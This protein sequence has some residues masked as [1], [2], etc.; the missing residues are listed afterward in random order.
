MKNYYSFLRQKL[1]KIK[2]NFFFR[3]KILIEI[4][5]LTSAL[6]VEECHFICLW[7]VDV[8][9]CPYTLTEVQ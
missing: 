5:E 9:L 8:F 7:I 4:V 3:L 1:S 2:E 6:D